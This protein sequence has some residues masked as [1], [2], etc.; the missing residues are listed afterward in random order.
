M[1]SCGGSDHTLVNSLA[2][3]KTKDCTVH[4]ITKHSDHRYITLDIISSP[5]FS[6]QKRLNT[7][8]RSYS[9]FSKIIKYFKSLLKKQLNQVSNTEQLILLRF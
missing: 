3:S 6:F 5:L 7:K 2:C 4:K 8:R 9:K 1:I